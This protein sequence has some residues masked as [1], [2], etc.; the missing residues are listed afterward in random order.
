M[1]WKNSFHKKTYE[2]IT[3]KILYDNNYKD[4]ISNYELQPNA[5]TKVLLKAL[6][7]KKPKNRYKITIS[8]RV[9][10]MMIKLLPTNILDCIFKI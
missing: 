4:I 5:L 2:D 10:K 3:L 8:T 1:D 6:Q 9:P 7:S